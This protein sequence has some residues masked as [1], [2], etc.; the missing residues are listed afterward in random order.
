MHGDAFTVT[1]TTADVRWM[2]RRTVKSCGP[3]SGMADEYQLLIRT[4]RWTREGVTCEAEQRHADALSTPA[5]A[6]SQRGS[7]FQLLQP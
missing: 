5:S 4:L 6:R 3:E 1:A 2:Q 7:T